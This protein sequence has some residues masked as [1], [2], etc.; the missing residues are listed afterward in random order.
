MAPEGNGF[1]FSRRARRLHWCPG[2][3]GAGP[4]RREDRCAAIRA[5]GVPLGIDL[6]GLSGCPA[7][8]RSPRGDRRRPGDPR[9]D[10]SFGRRG[11]FVP[12]LAPV[13]AAAQPNRPSPGGGGREPPGVPRTGGFE[14]SHARPRRRYPVRR[15]AATGSSGHADRL[16]AGRSLLRPRRA[17]DRVTPSGHRRASWPAWPTSATGGTACSS[18]ST[19]RRPSARPTG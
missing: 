2:G 13:R 8:A 5:G 18:S 1:A 10:R 15:R 12:G 9:V 6:P 14:L 19:T 17:D 7:P 11:P 16:G 3:P 4:C